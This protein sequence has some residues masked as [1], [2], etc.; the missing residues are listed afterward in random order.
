[1]DCQGCEA[2]CCKYTPIEI[3]VDEWNRF[4]DVIPM[5]LK[6]FEKGILRRFFIIPDCPFLKENKC[7]IY[8]HRPRMCRMY[9]LNTYKTSFIL[10]KYCPK[11]EGIIIEKRAQELEENLH[12]GIENIYKE[13]ISYSGMDAIDIL[14][15]QRDAND[16]NNEV[17]EWLKNYHPPEAL[18][19]KQYYMLNNF[20]DI[21][22]L[23]EFFN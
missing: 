10:T 6:V 22:K 21:P 11:A 4:K 7:S 18:Q 3:Y 20:K 16:L 23:K 5:Q 14:Q 1:M 17:R 9:P 12:I 2:I 13:M 8:E 15:L 19:N